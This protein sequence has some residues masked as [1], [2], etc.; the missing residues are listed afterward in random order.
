M[1]AGFLITI[2]HN[3]FP[4]ILKGVAEKGK[5]GVDIS[6]MVANMGQD[7]VQRPGIHVLVLYL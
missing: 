3:V 1:I 7:G 5:K 6:I 2:L 4:V